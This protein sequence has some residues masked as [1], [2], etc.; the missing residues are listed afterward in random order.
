MTLNNSRIFNLTLDFWVWQDIEMNTS[1]SPKLE[2]IKPQKIGKLP[3]VIL[4]LEDFE[5]MKENLEM[6]QSK[7]LVKDIAKARQEVSK[8]KVLSFEEVKRKLML[9]AI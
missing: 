7:K 9:M 2:N 4:P 8:G 3:V 1:I 5:T 6:Y